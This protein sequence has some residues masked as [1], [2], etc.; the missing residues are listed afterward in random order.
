MNIE[1]NSALLIIDAQNKY[2][3]I[4][5]KKIKKNMEKITE[6]FYNNNLPVYI[7]QF[8]RC[9]FKNNCTR[10]HKN[11]TI[12]NQLSYLKS[13]KSNKWKN[14]L[15]K[16]GKTKKYKCPSYYCHIIDELK[17]YST[18]KNTFISNNLDSLENKE[19]NFLVKKN[20]IKNLYIIG[21]WGS[22]C[23]LATAYGCVTKR[24]IMPHIINDSIF[25]CNNKYYDATKKIIDSI[26]K[27]V[28][29]KDIL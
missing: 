20:N 18:K 29:I 26:F 7:T 12:V 5:K 19:L 3:Y 14:N 10:K 25:D 21:G 1:K 28:T 16:L 23:I 4:M 6:Y 2:N 11:E 8:S 9:K 24:N 22:H 17:K 13:K 27:Y 15:Y